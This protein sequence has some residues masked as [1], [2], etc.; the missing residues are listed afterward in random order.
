[1]ATRLTPAALRRSS[2]S[3]ECTPR[4][5]ATRPGGCVIRAP[6]GAPP[7]PPPAHARW[8]APGSGSVSRCLPPRTS[9][10]HVSAKLDQRA[11]FVP[12]NGA[13]VRLEEAEHL[14]TGGH[15]FALQ[16]ATACL[17]D[18]PLDQWQHLCRL[19]E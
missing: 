9:C 7:L 16:H 8:D 1:M 3:A 13:G 11:A 4:S 15:L 18:H 17:S 2:V 6:G 5:P 12:W 10:D 19:A 14:L